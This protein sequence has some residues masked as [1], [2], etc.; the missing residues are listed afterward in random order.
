MNTFTFR[1]FCIWPS[2]NANS[3][4]ILDCVAFNNWTYTPYNWGGDTESK[5]TVGSLFSAACPGLCI[6]LTG[7]CS[8]IAMLMQAKKHRAQAKYSILFYSQEWGGRLCTKKRQTG[9]GGGHRTYLFDEGNNRGGDTAQY[10][11]EQLGC[12]GW[13]VAGLGSSKTDL[14]ATL[15][16]H[17]ASWNL[18]K[19]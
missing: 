19:I 8:I 12:G 13:E 15:W 4:S 11:K 5:R 3:H 10:R 16:L 14:K 1:E 2:W 7:Q 9:K 6:A 18:P 17:L